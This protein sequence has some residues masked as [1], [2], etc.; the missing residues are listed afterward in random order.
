MCIFS[1]VPLIV[2]AFSE[3]EMLC[4]LMVAVLLVIVGM[5]VS[6][7]IIVGVRNAS[8]QKL[9][10]EGEYTDSAKTSN[11]LQEI[12]GFAYW[13]ILVASYLAWSFLTSDWHI[14]WIVFV[15]GAVLDPVVA[16]ICDHIAGKKNKN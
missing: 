9:L 3:N 15:V 7:F 12:V 6:A 2:S 8:M 5:A 13:G 1:P 4:V 14:T 10:R 11:A 16:K